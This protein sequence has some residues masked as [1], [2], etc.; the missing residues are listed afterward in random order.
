M[1]RQFALFSSS[2]SKTYQSSE[3]KDHRFSIFR[4]NMAYIELHNRQNFTYSLRMNEFGDMTFDEFRLHYTSIHL[5]EKHREGKLKSGSRREVEWTLL[6]GENVLPEAVDWRERGCVTEIKNQEKCGSCWAF[7][8]TGAIEGAMCA[9][10]GVL[11]NLS[12]QQLVDCAHQGNLGCDGGE[13]DWAFQYVVNQ[14]GLCREEEYPYTSHEIG[15]CAAND[16]EP[17]GGI[18]GFRDVPPMSERA[19]R[20]ALA[21]YGPVAVSI[22]ADQAP[23]QFYHDGVFN[24]PCGAELDHAVLAVGYGT[25]PVSG[26]DYFIVKN[27]WGMQWG[28]GGFMRMVRTEAKHHDKHHQDNGECGILSDPSFV[29]V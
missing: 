28:E 16:C 21:K 23:F 1:E 26:L 11:P 24:G 9:Q 5:K 27:S 17:V 4:E 19:L 29:L 3:E 22:E 13:P 10:T 14:G 7:S 25:D 8:T 6:D 12:E 20:A 15:F 18:Q 2:F